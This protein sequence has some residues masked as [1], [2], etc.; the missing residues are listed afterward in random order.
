[1][2]KY[3]IELIFSGHKIKL[4]KYIK[5]NNQIY[6]L[7]QIMGKLSPKEGYILLKTI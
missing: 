1:M 3:V 7:T 4:N 6:Q 5:N 2:D